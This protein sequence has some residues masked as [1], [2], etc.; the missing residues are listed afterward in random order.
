VEFANA[1]A[2]QGEGR[3]ELPPLSVV[4]MSFILDETS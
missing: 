2:T 1:S 4:A 3:V